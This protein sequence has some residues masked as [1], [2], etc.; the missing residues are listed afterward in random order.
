MR[1]GVYPVFL[2]CALVFTAP[3]W[4][5]SDNIVLVSATNDAE[6]EAALAQQIV[7]ESASM[8][9]FEDLLFS[10]IEQEMVLRRAAMT[11][12]TIEANPPLSQILDD[13]IDERMV[14]SRAIFREHYPAIRSAH[15]QFYVDAYTSDEL[16]QIL[17]FVSTQTGKK[18]VRSFAEVRSNQAIGT[19]IAN[20]AA[21]IE[22]S[23]EPSVDQLSE[24]LTDY[25]YSAAE[26]E[27]VQPD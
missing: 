3:A 5:Q 9:Q 17:A 18:Y 8:V 10:S 20:F 21:D 6:T 2:T 13:W 25:I 1:S 15:E 24:R 14:N 7:A 12:P 26:G 4:A 11:N 19:A 27:L 16:R 23:D 22:Q